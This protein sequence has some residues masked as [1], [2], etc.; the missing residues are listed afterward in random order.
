[1]GVSPRE[2]LSPLKI[3]V[4]AK[5]EINLTFGEIS[6]YVT[7][8]GEFLSSLE[9]DR[10]PVIDDEDREIVLAFP[11]KVRGIREVLARDHMKCVFFGR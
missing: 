1:M 7:E 8:G 2:H 6:K 11:E 5:K 9:L 3:F 4:L 10:M